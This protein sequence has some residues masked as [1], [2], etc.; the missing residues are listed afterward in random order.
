MEKSPDQINNRKGGRGHH[1]TQL[2]SFSLLILLAAEY[3]LQA[4]QTQPD[5][6]GIRMFGMSTLSPHCAAL[7]CD[8]LHKRGGG[9]EK[10]LHCYFFCGKF[11]SNFP[12][13]SVGVLSVISNGANFWG[14]LVHNQPV[15]SA[16]DKFWKS[17]QGETT[18]CTW[19]W[20]VI[21]TSLIVWTCLKEPLAFIV[22]DLCLL[23]HRSPQLA[24]PTCTEQIGSGTHLNYSRGLV[25]WPKVAWRSQP[26]Q[27]MPHLWLS[28]LFFLISDLNYQRKSAT[29]NNSQNLPF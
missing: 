3:F 18:D 12:G 16:E 11:P 27:Q 23:L 1:K 26:V 5:T 8:S 21:Q 22:V 19:S 2:S 10:E 9:C 29:A 15:I 14:F 7:R 24:V 4:S 17:H 20:S 25:F 28:C 13:T 6:L